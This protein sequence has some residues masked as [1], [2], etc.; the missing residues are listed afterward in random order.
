MTRL[1]G[2]ARAVPIL[3]ANRSGLSPTFVL[4]M[5]R[6]VR[7][8]RLVLVNAL[9]CS[10]SDTKATRV[11]NYE[12]FERAVDEPVVSNASGLSSYQNSA[13]DDVD[14][15]HSRRQSMDLSHDRK[16]SVSLDDL[17]QLTPASSSSLALDATAQPTKS[18]LRTGGANTRRPK[19]RRVT[20]QQEF[21]S[22]VV[23]KARYNLF[24]FLPLFLFT[25]FGRLANLYTL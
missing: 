23:V 24:T 18:R 25:Q 17:D 21:P 14:S 1:H 15:G 6:I 13:A 22:N 5:N 16:E 9:C 12:G 19:V 10:F 7:E 20:V 2:L 3:D 11:I 8:Q 4:T